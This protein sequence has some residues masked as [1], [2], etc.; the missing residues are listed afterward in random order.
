MVYFLWFPIFRYLINPPGHPPWNRKDVEKAMGGLEEIRNRAAHARPRYITGSVRSMA[1][2]KLERL[3][4][5]MEFDT[6]KAVEN[7]RQLTPT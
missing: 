7:I 1:M 3:M 5:G 2:Q 6:N 4:V